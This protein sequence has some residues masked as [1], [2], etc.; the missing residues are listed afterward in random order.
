MDDLQI[1]R[2]VVTEPLIEYGGCVNLAQKEDPSYG[3]KK[4]FRR[5]F[6]YRL[7]HASY[8]LPVAR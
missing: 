8:R 5:A 6:V 4:A 7:I 2:R 1:F 3:K